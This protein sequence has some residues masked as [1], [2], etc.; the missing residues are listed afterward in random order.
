M[1]FFSVRKESAVRKAAE[2]GHPVSWV[3]K[4]ERDSQVNE[5]GQNM[6]QEEAARVQAWS[7]KR[8]A[9]GVE[10][11]QCRMAEL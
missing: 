9:S 3:L 5:K 8:L 6:P 11:E 2:E 1:F 7:V 4:A 10:S